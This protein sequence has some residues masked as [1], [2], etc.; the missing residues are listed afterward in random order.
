MATS[1]IANTSTTS[2][3]QQIKDRGISRTVTSGGATTQL[4]TT[5]TKTTL[6]QNDFLRLMT[7]QMQYQDPFNPVDNTQM[8]SQMATLSQVSG[9]AQMNSSLSA[10]STRLGSTSTADA[11]SYV[12]K[13][14]LT[15]G[16]TAQ[17]RV[18]GGVAGAVELA[19]DATSVD[20][21]IFDAD[22]QNVKTVK[23]G[24]QA[25]GT[26]DYEWDGKDAGGN[27]VSNG[28]YTIKVTAL[29]RNAAT[30]TTPAGA[31]VKANSLVWAPVETVSLPAGGD[32]VLNVTGLGTV[33][34]SAIRKVA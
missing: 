9:I 27:K 11:M 28:P 30:A 2:L 32:P 3:D 22:G 1:T 14:V 20:V 6:G 13:T 21:D 25:S 4:N 16:T 33:K 5:G 19:G 26:V 24:A 12:G 17:E 23:L 34:P 31:A 29:D 8:V 10:I 15:D 7:A 18:S